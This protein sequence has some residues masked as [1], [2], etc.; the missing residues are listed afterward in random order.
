[1]DYFHELL[2][3]ESLIPGGPGEFPHFYAVGAYHLQ[4]PSILLPD[5]LH[6]MRTSFEEALS[7][8]VTIAD[9]RR[10]T[11]HATNGPTRVARRQGDGSHP[12]DPWW[13]TS[14]RM[15]VLDVCRVK[16]VQTVYAERTRMWAA[17]IVTELDRAESVASG[18]SKARPES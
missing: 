5:A 8:G 15:T 4:H 14:W 3:L 13:P 12:I 9:L 2:V 1:M 7:G 17:N 16:P 6:N 10:R 18:K 11:R